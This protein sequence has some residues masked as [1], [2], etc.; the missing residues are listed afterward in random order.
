[1][2]RGVYMMVLSIETKLNYCK[3]NERKKKYFKTYKKFK[4]IRIVLLYLTL[5]PILQWTDS[6]LSLSPPNKA[7]PELVLPEHTLQKSI[8]AQSP[9]KTICSA[10]RTLRRSSYWFAHYLWSIWS[11]SSLGWLYSSSMSAHS[12]RSRCLPALR[13]NCVSL[14]SGSCITRI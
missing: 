2:K 10:I 6:V 11:R 13:C 7:Y 4:I 1:M 3:K 14:Y 9:T 8:N 12:S 5:V